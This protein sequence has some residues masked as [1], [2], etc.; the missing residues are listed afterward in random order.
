MSFLITG[1]SVALWGSAAVSTVTAAVAYRRRAAPGGRA[2]ALMLV[3]VAV[4]GSM[5]GFESA[6]V[7]LPLKIRFSQLTYVGVVGVAPLFLLF[8]VAYTG[9]KPFRLGFS[10]LLWVVPLVT[11]ALAFTNGSHGLVWKSFTADPSPQRNLVY[12][13]HGPWYWVSLGYYV[14][15]VLGATVIILHAS[16]RAPRIYLRQ[17]LVMI[18]GVVVPWLGEVL[19]VSPRNPF[20]GLDLT[21]IGFAVTGILLLYGFSRL[22]L[23]DVVPMAR[24]L[25]VER[26]RGGL[27]VLDLKGRLVDLNAAAR[28]MLRAEDAAVGKPAA[29]ALPALA[30]HLPAPGTAPEDQTHEIPMP[31]TEDRRLELAVS[32]LRDPMGRSGG[33]LIVLQDVTARHRMEQ[34]R[35]K[36]IGELTKALADVR[37]LQGLLPICASCGK[38]RNDRGYWEN[39]EHY[40]AA[41]TGA[42]FTHGLC[43]ECIHMLYPELDEPP[44][45]ADAPP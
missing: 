22:R 4:W 13:G 39:I 7:G 25:L 38:I 20:P 37:T 30:A 45:S 18:A 27:V 28:Q 32:S 10:L 19:Y 34:E 5:A 17:T 31:G 11:V 12:Y 41:H 26:M 21:Q 6:A 8:S 23:F 16:I 1:Y 9:R 42:Q 14:A 33:V 24:S 44:P 15:L 43:E 3:C 2:L 40:L 35:E 36:L 29:L